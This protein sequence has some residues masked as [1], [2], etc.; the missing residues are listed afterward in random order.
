M[1]QVELKDMAQSC[2]KKLQDSIKDFD[3][4]CNC[5]IGF[6]SVDVDYYTSTTDC[7][8]IFNL[9]SDNYLPYVFT[10]F[11]DVYNIDYNEFCGELLVI[12]EVNLK[13]ENRKITKAEIKG[14]QKDQ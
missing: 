14:H 11:D 8:K 3:Q 1:K 7:L 13:N 5:P 10:Y 2:I 4:Y 9:P 12:N 6:V